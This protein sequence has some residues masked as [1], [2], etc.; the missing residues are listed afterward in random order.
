M[1]TSYRSNVKVQ[2]NKYL[3][4]RQKLMAKAK[5]WLTLTSVARFI[6][7]L[8]WDQ[9]QIFAPMS[10]RDKSSSLGIQKL[11]YIM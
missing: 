1:Q 4:L 10:F 2:E 5:V 3:L 8:S 11:L 7:K 9:C 6:I